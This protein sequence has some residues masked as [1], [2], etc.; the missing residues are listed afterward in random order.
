MTVRKS[1]T[2]FITFIATLFLAWSFLSFS[3]TEAETVG[4]LPSFFYSYKHLVRPNTEDLIRLRFVTTFDFPP[5]NFLD[6]TGYLAGY[7]VDLLR[8]ICSKLNLQKR[9]E[10]EVVPWEELVSHVKD[11]GAEVIIAGLK[12]TMKTYQDIVFTKSYL[13]FPAR[14]VASQFVK[15]DAPINDKLEHLRTGLLLKSAHKKLF[16]SYFPEA[17]W[18]GFKDRTTLYQALRDHKIDLIFDDGFAL[19]LWLNSQKSKDCCH[20]VGGAYMAPQLLGQG[21]RLAVAKKN[22]KLIDILNYALK[23]LEDDGKLAELYLRYFPISFY[24]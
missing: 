14:F 17:Q 19:S 1:V 10:V 13:R 18:Q 20:F 21:M 24:E 5:F 11:G 12:E 2:K 16:Q 3:F 8:A 9:C 15:F 23:S 4:K 6:Q 22:E 7:N